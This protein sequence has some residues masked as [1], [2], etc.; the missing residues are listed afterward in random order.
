MIEVAAGEPIQAAVDRAGDGDVVVIPAGTYHEEVVVDRAGVTL[1]GVDRNEVVLDGRDDL[2]NGVTVLAD[3]VTVENLTVHHYRGNGVLVSGAN[4]DDERRQLDG[5]RLAYLSAYDNALYGLYAFEAGNGT[6]SDSYVSGH[7]DSGIYVG[8]CGRPASGDTDGYEPC[9]VV[10]QRVAAELNAVGYSGTNA[11]QVWI[12]E[13]IFRRNRIGLTPN[14][15]S[16]EFRAPQTDA[17]IAGNLVV[18]NDAPDAPEQA[19]GGFGIGIAIGSGTGNVVVRNR[20]EG[21]DG[22]GILVTA[23][24]RFTPLD[25]RVEGNL[26][27]ANEL[28]L[29]YWV[30]GGSTPTDGNCFVDNTFESSSPDEIERVLPCEG[31][32]TTVVA[33]I[34]RLPASPP[35]PRPADVPA[36]PAQPNRPGDPRS[37]EPVDDFFVEPD[38][39]RITVPERS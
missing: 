36:P 5:F 33:E 14:S 34:V 17:V 16:L 7:G 15:Q 6:I 35:G 23:L 32:D 30:T 11:S 38:L 18:D 12:V 21:H 39:T 24:D 25:N 22:A 2:I 10:V 27:G 19:A 29:G 9:N 4:D 37:L 1:R 20:V 13:S 8:Q 31:A 28:D 26:V 3:R